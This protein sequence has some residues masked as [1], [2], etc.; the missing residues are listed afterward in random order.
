MTYAEFTEKIGTLASYVDKERRLQEIG[1][2]L[3]DVTGQLIDDYVHLLVLNYPRCRDIIP[4]FIWEL[5]FGSRWSPYF[6]QDDYGRDIRLDTVR[7]LW[8]ECERSIDKRFC[9]DDPFAGKGPVIEGGRYHGIDWYICWNGMN[10]TAYINL[11]GTRFV[12]VKNIPCHGGITWAEK[13][14]PFESGDSFS[15]DRWIVGWDYNHAGDLESF[16]T[17]NKIESDIFKVISYCE[18]LPY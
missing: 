16:F 10:W 17:R 15:E 9:E 6:W 13:F 12:G 14:Y 1:I 8:E 5:D 3:G 11:S 4:M 2:D 7:A 18:K